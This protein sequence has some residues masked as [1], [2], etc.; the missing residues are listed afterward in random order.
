V[1]NEYLNTPAR[2][3]A[4]NIE[5]LLLQGIGEIARQN[6]LMVAYANQLPKGR[7]RDATFEA[8]VTQ[9][10]LLRMLDEIAPD[11]IARSAEA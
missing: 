1:P 4:A 7:L 8:L 10:R 6:A 5:A 9:Q 2:L 3:H 11:V